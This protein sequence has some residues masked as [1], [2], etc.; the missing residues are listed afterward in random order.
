M[1][2]KGKPSQ[3]DALEATPED[4]LPQLS[5]NTRSPDVN[6]WFASMV[7]DNFSCQNGRTSSLYMRTNGGALAIRKGNSWVQF[8]RGQRV[9]FWQAVMETYPEVRKSNW[10]I[11]RQQMLWEYFLTYAPAGEFDDRRYFETQNC[12]LDGKTGELD[13]SP[14]RFLDKPTVRCSPL[15]YN[16]EYAPTPAW[17]EW[18]DG[19]DEHQRRIRQ[20]SVG[21]AVTGG[22]GLLMTFGQSRTGKSTLA[23]G[24]TQAL[25]SGTSTFSLAKKWNRFDTQAFDNTTYLYDPDSKGSKQQNNDNYETVHMMASGD[26]IMMEIKQGASYRSTN[27][28]FIE[29]ISNAPV[30]VTFE[31][32][33]VDRV[34][35]CLYT[36]VGSKAD[37]GHMKAMILA[38]RQAWLNYAI[39]C[40]IAFRKEGRPKV[41]KYQVYGWVQWLGQANAYGRACVER[42]HMLS[43]SEYR[44]ANDQGTRYLLSRDS[45]ETI[46]A[47][48]RE[49]NRQYGSDILMV[50]W[51]A[52]GEELKKQYYDKTTKLF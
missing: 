26:P 10:S 31:Q 18:H 24:L 43:Y 12:I 6:Q 35:F 4:M 37:D 47:G 23:E 44:Y 25:G 46:Q 22:Y 28:G 50:D 52:Y 19:M 29:M 40:A 33:L 9:E 1:V 42:K 49:L 48:I 8:H 39:D 34:R 32:S 15:P 2:A 38:D 5:E 13:Y 3:V 16:P 21:A 20:W 36:Y 27:Y 45:V 51:D 11:K 17:R 30:P 7:L 41:D 14:T